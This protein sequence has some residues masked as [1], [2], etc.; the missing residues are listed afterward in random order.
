MKPITSKEQ[1]RRAEAWLADQDRR[2]A[3]K[4]PVD[5]RYEQVVHALVVYDWTGGPTAPPVSQP[6]RAEAWIKDQVRRRDAAGED[7]DPH[8]EAV[9]GEWLIDD[10]QD[11]PMSRHLDLELAA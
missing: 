10:W 4:Q 3:K 9:L 2:R 5:P 8:Y 11:A 6:K 7:V 1:A